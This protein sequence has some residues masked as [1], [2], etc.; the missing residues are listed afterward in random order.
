MGWRERMVSQ[1]Y[2]AFLFYSSVIKRQEGGGGPKNKL[3]TTSKS[4][5]GTL[6]VTYFSHCSSIHLIYNTLYQN[7]VQV[8]GQEDH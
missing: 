2:I 3:R 8:L 5:K 6:Y 1:S 4:R 7:K